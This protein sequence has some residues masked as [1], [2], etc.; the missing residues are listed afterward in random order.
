MN[1]DEK[2][3]SY[4]RSS[5]ILRSNKYWIGQN[6]LHNKKK[7]S[8]SKIKYKNRRK[9]HQDHYLNHNFSKGGN[10]QGRWEEKENKE[11]IKVIGEYKQ[12][13]NIEY[14][15][16]LTEIASQY[17]DQKPKSNTESPVYYKPDR[18]Y[19]R[20]NSRKSS[21]NLSMF[22]KSFLVGF[23][24]KANFILCFL[25]IT[26]IY[27]P[28]FFS[29]AKLQQ[30]PTE[31]IKAYTDQLDIDVADII[32]SRIKRSASTLSEAIENSQE[33][34]KSSSKSVKVKFSVVNRDGVYLDKDYLNAHNIHFKR[35]KQLPESQRQTRNVDK[36]EQHLRKLYGLYDEVDIER[37][38]RQT[39]QIEKNITDNI[40]GANSQGNKKIN[41]RPQGRFATPM[42]EKNRTLES[43]IEDVYGYLTTVYIIVVI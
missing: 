3:L 19:S 9:H 23:L 8:M 14:S 31:S 21:I 17:N 37:Y 34:E 28:S 36:T 25:F 18:E 1:S 15:S 40:N 24:T 42:N 30:R 35:E 27:Q 6:K 13:E 29:Q 10:D 4:T 2:G 32:N 33:A 41:Y 11:Q 16:R 22:R 12:R 7:L 20:I 38:R 5:F 26:S 39:I 43:P